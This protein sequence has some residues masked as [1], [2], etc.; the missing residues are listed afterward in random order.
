MPKRRP[1]NRLSE[2]TPKW[3]ALLIDMRLVTPKQAHEAHLRAVE[4]A[5]Q[6]DGAAH[7]QPP[8]RRRSRKPD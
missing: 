6:K 8:P 3:L 7:D 4:Q 5:E 1:T 2:C